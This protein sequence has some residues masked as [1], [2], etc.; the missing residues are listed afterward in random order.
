[1]RCVVGLPLRSTSEDV[2]G[3][4]FALV[5]KLVRTDGFSNVVVRIY[6]Q[7][8]ELLYWQIFL[9]DLRSELT[10]QVL[11]A[12]VVVPGGIVERDVL[13]A[14]LEHGGVRA[15]CIIS[16]AR[17]SRHVLDGNKLKFVRHA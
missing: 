1:M 15:A 5:R 4:N 14:E 7:F 10:Y 17:L 9:I 13:S 8:L 12:E 6:A 3:A 16:D 11:V 2:T